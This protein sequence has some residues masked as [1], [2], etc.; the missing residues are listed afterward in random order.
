M[1]RSRLTLFLFNNSNNI[2]SLGSETCGLLIYLV[3]VGTFFLKEEST[4]RRTTWL[5]KVGY[6][7]GMG[8]FRGPHSLH[9][10]PRFTK[11]VVL[12]T[13]IRVEFDK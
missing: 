8:P 12:S 5:V 7:Q 6:I 1:I 11:Q 2:S 3:V 13:T 9:I 4:Q 10:N